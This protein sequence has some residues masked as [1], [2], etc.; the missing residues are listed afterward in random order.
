MLEKIEK[1]EQKPQLRKGF[2]KPHLRVYGH[3]STITR[4]AHPPGTGTDGAH[5]AP[6]KSH[7][8]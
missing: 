4:T 2:R 1:K 3:I 7:T 5:N 8:T 6:N